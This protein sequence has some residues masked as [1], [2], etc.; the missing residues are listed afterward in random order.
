M[1][2]VK[3]RTLIQSTISRCLLA[4]SILSFA[5]VFLLIRQNPFANTDQSDRDKLSGRPKF[6]ELPIQV[7]S[8]EAMRRKLE[9]TNLA[10]RE[11]RDNPEKTREIL[12][13][14]EK[15][16]IAASKEISGPAISSWIQEGMNAH[17]GIEFSIG[18]Q[19]RL[20]G[21]PSLRVALLDW[22]LRI[23]SETAT[24]LSKSVLQ[25]PTDPDEWAVCLRNVAVSSKSNF[26]K[27]YLK[28][29][30]TELIQN[31]T[32]RADSSIS[33]LES[34]DILTYTG[35]TD[36]IPLLAGIAC[37]TSSTGQARAHA[38]TLTLDRLAF[39]K[40]VETMRA[41]EGNRELARLRGKFVACLFA[42]AD[43]SDPVQESLVR[44]YLLN[45]SRSQ[46]E[47]ETFATVFP[48]ANFTVSKNLISNNQSLTG[49]EISARDSA[50][51]TTIGEWSC[52]PSMQR[53]RWVLDTVDRRLAKFVSRGNPLPSAGQ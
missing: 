4:I 37:E 38:A 10:I 12:L 42:R 40:P 43:V 53:I 35:A 23:D 51:L 2:T 33:Y 8:V 17:T 20:D 15:Q 5:I 45:S 26:E 24:A 16:L 52:D 28:A 6:I 7:K 21:H 29:K 50:A 41:L 31:S 46:S 39:A 19:G 32:W 30:T 36:S 44:D 47:L 34:F 48:N 9:S 22:L 13:D 1:L 25:T 14:L 27:N 11:H 49:A 3:H 18:H